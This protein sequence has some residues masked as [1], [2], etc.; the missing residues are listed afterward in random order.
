M[1][2]T[3]ESTVLVNENNKLFGS[4]LQFFNNTNL[5]DFQSSF[6]ADTVFISE[7]ETDILDDP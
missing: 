7:R 2:K 3:V 5:N 6:F 4:P 1:D